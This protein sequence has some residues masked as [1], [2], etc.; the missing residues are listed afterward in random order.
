MLTGIASSAL[1]LGITQTKLNLE[2][3]RVKEKAHQELKEYTENIKSMV[4]SGVDSFG[5][6]P[7]GGVDVTLTSD[8]KGNPTLTGKL[9][10]EI[11]KSSASGTYSIFYYIH[12]YLIWQDKGRFFFQKNADQDNLDTLEFKSYQVRFSQ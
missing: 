4:A 5:F 1:L 6:A 9:H 7:P 8:S 2:S 10:R 12:T 3:I 11:R